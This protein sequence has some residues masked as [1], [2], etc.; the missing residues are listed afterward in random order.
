MNRR[1][2]IEALRK[3]LSRLSEEEIEAAIEYYEEY[4]DEA[5][6]ENEQQV[7]ADLGSPKKIA[8]QIKSEYGARILNEETENPPAKKKLSAAWWVI[9]G[10]CSLPVSIPLLFLMI[11]GIITAAGVAIAVLAG[12]AGCIVGAVALV[13]VGII[14]IPVA[15]SSALFFLGI[16]LASLAILLAVGALC[17]IGIKAA[18]KAIAR[19][20]RNR[21]ERKRMERSEN[22]NWKWKGENE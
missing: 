6:P 10:V 7:I 1:E 20:V 16:G 2:F 13:L 11:C 12:I 18:V 5:G 8:A 4:F 14:S 19:A 21:S 15:F 17:I 9:L 22:Q 3:E